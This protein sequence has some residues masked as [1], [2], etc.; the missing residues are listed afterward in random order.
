M[1]WFREVEEYSSKDDEMVAIGEVCGE[2]AFIIFGAEWQAEQNEKF[3]KILKETS[4]K[5]S[6]AFKQMSDE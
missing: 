1:K 4:S 2:R 5:Y 6:E 3:D